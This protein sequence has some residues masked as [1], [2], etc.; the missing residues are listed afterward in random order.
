MRHARKAPAL[1]AALL[2]T[3]CAET[4]DYVA[5]NPH[6][7]LSPFIG[8]N[9]GAAGGQAIGSA[10]AV[11]G[12]SAAGAIVGFAAG[13]YLAKRDVVFFDK[14]IDRT[15]V[16]EPG[17]PVS[18]TNPNTGTR[19]TMTRLRDV[20]GPGTDTC[21][22]LRSEV[23]AAGEDTVEDMVVCRPAFGTWYIDWGWPPDPHPAG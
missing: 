8:A 15:A 17:K 21:R 9:A 7:V 10:T 16:A 2:L 22:L 3:A 11:F 6:K 12:M 4:A 18:W 5:E 23:K 20:A 14:A 13:P 19:G 1:L